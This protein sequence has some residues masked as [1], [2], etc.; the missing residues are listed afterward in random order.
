[1]ETLKRWTWRGGADAGR[2][3]DEVRQR[4]L[5]WFHWPEAASA[6]A[7]DPWDIATRLLGARPFRVRS[8]RL[9]VVG[10]SAANYENSS[11]DARLHTDYD[12]YLPAHLQ[13]LICRRPA[14][15]A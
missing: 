5:S 2:V 1:M 4:G 11:V 9:E 10:R 3:L 13:V 12:P 6:A 15:D 8:R 7:D 14:A